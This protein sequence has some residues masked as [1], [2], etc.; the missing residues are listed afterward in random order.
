[1]PFSVQRSVKS[2]LLRWNTVECLKS[3]PAQASYNQLNS[4]RAVKLESL[5]AKLTHFGE[6]LFPWMPWK[7]F[8][9]KSDFRPPT[10]RSVGLLFGPHGRE[11]TESLINL[12][13]AC[14]VLSLRGL[15]SQG[16]KKLLVFVFHAE[17]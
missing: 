4:F 11:Q 15:F 17:F 8:G 16:K 6:D 13:F 2:A 10:V 3:F 5:I 14:Q 1:M 7:R 12:A 9:D